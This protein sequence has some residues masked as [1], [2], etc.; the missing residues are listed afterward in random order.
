MSKT[1]DDERRIDVRR[2]ERTRAA[3]EPVA[4]APEPVSVAAPPAV[5]EPLPA[6]ITTAAF[7][8]GDEPPARSAPP[9]AAA[10]APSVSPDAVLDARN[11]YS[12]LAFLI[13]FGATLGVVSIVRAGLQRAPVAIPAPRVTPQ[14][15]PPAPMSAAPGVSVAPPRAQRS[16]DPFAAAL[17]P[18]PEDAA[19]A[20]ATR[21]YHLMEA[22]LRN[23]ARTIPALQTNPPVPADP[24]NIPERN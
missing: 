22:A 4:A 12:A 1:I 8:R 21:V 16:R 6:A 2:R 19:L 14:P 20:E 23:A 24:L 18:E 13:V 5:P 10:P 9:P 11:R 17:L 7:E 15:A 3:P